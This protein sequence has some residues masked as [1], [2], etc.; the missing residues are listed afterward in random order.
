[1]PQIPPWKKIAADPGLRRGLIRRSAILAAVRDFFAGRGFLEVETP[2]L[3]RHP[4]MEPNLDPFATRLRRHDG[5]EFAAH[6][7]T[8]PEY[9]L[10]KL[11]AAG[12]EKVFEIT[13]CFRNGEPWGEA[14]A[15]ERPTHNPEFTMI[16][17]YRAGADYT[18][19]MK[20]VEEMVAELSERTGGKGRVTY[21]GRTIDFRLPWPRL[22]VAEAFGR[23]AGIDLGRAMD[24]H[25]WFR[26]AAA[27]RGALITAQ[28]SFDD[29][30]FKVFLRDIEP[31]LGMPAAEGR[32]ARPLIL[33]DYPGTM[34]ALARLKQPERRYAERFEVYC[35]GL[36]LANAFSELNDADE[37]RR[38]LETERAERLRAGKAAYDID[39]QFLDAVAD[40]PDSAGI[41][42]GLDRLVMLLTDAPSIRDVLFFPA[43]DLFGGRPTAGSG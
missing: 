21:Q 14:G 18:A 6:L 32:A 24:D 28:E 5:V 26:R 42:L 25:E 23:Y 9:S 12:F 13:K 17:W 8:S 30:F 40:M 43:D 20:D 29:V 31:E 3:V 10:K 37:Q 15:G 27:D 2:I 16:E 4:G 11:L 7:I 41:A 39:E 36:E 34:A 1:M 22:S 38:R 19:I 33:H 35:L